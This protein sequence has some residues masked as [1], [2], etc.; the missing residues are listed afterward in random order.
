MKITLSKPVQHGSETIT[1]LDLREPK[2]G[3]MRGM[4]LQLD[5]DAMLMLASRCVAQPPSVI[6]ELSFA[7]LTAVAEA[8]GDFLGNGLPTGKPQ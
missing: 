4:P 8:L 3:D 6:N 2:A 7:D 1:E 5:W